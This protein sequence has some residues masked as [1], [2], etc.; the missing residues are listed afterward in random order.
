MNANAWDVDDCKTI[1]DDRGRLLVIESD[2]V[3][4]ENFRRLYC[5]VFEKKGITRGH[6]AHK[7]LQ[8]VLVVINGAISIMLDDGRRRE[9]F[10]ITAESNA[11]LKIS[12]PAWREIT[13]L[14]D[15]TIIAVLADEPYHEDDYLRNYDD[16][17]DYTRES[18]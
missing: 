2:D 1:V 18:S 15:N 12:K 16:F 14:H 8:Q 5:I 10:K 11:R 9:T 6:H 13:A 7:A 3:D 4:I 17:I